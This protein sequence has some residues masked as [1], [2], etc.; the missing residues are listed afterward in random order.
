MTVPSDKP[1]TDRMG[2]PPSS[3]CMYKSHALPTMRRQ[4]IAR[5]SGVHLTVALS[6]RRRSGLQSSSGPSAGKLWVRKNVAS[7]L[8][9]IG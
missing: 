2:D 8:A 1:S 5:P 3:G 4:V 6:A 9:V 7:Y